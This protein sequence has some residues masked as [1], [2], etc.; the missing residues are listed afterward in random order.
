MSA[1]EVELDALAAGDDVATD[2]ISL[3]H[4]QIVKMTYGA[5]GSQ[6]LASGG[7]GPTDAGTARVTLSSDSTGVLSVD[8]NG[9][10]LTVDNAGTFATQATLQTA[11]AEIGNVKNSGTFVTQEN[12]AALTALQ[13]LDDTVYVENAALG[14]SPSGNLMMARQD[15]VLSA[16]GSVDDDA[17]PLTVDA[18]G[19]MWVTP[20]GTV[21]VDGSGVTQPVSGT[22]TA[23]LSPTDNAVLDNIQTSVDTVAAAVSTQMQVDVVGALPPGANAIGK[24]SAN[25]GVDIGD[26]GVTSIAAGNSLIGDVGIS[27]A[28]TSGGTTFY[29]NI[30]VDETEDSVK[31]SAGQVYWIQCTNLAASVIYLHFYNA[32]VA[33]VTVGTTTPDLT[34]AI[35]TQG[36]ANGA[37]FVLTIPNGIAFGTAITVAATTTVGGS[38]GP[39]ANEV[40]LNIGYA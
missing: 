38:T 33:S 10:S 15:A 8:D 27:G 13:V 11:T 3:R 14:A 21:T 1:S 37:G 2:L 26:V 5:L 29:R 16:T 32:T 40:L 4:Y 24:L 22:I 35:P 20:S 7:N 12:G 36:D 9:G 23:N 25:S 18:N 6:T 19:A 31:A 30:D 17:T 34:F 28:R 39:A